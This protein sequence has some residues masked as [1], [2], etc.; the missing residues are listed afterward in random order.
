M[1]MTALGQTGS[2]DG[3]P[4]DGRAG[5]HVRFQLGDTVRVGS[6]FGTVT[7]VGTVLIQFKTNDGCLRVACPWEVER[8]SS[9]PQ[10]LGLLW[11]NSN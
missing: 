3:M 4:F 9:L 2:G 8:I 11:A 1:A 5:R 7:D 6:R 10:G